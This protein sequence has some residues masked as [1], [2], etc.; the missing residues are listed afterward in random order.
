MITGAVALLVVHCGEDETTGPKEDPGSG[1]WSNCFGNHQLPPE[2]LVKPGRLRIVGQ[3]RGGEAGVEGSSVGGSEGGASGGSG[4]GEAGAGGLV[5]PEGAGA[6]A[7][8]AGSVQVNGELHGCGTALTITQTTVLTGANFAADFANGVD[9]RGAGCARAGAASPDAVFSVHVPSGATVI[10][11]ETAR[12]FSIDPVIGFA[13]SCS[14][15]IEC[16]ASSAAYDVNAW[17]GVNYTAERDE[18]ITA[19]VSSER[20]YAAPYR[21]SLEYPEALGVVTAGAS[22]PVPGSEALGSDDWRTFR[23]DAA[24]PVVLYGELKSEG[25]VGDLDFRAFNSEAYFSTS[26]NDGDEHVAFGVPAGRFFVE[27]RAYDAVNGYSLNLFTDPFR[28]VMDPFD[29]TD[30]PEHEHD[31][32]AAIPAGRSLFYRITALEDAAIRINV[33]ANGGDPALSLYEASGQ[34]FRTWQESEGAEEFL[35]ARISAVPSSPA[36]VLLRVHAMPEGGE[37]SSHRVQISVAVE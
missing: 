36:V 23:I 14:N 37:I 26:F 5:Q 11:R 34:F 18:T 30:N 33:E 21:I 27:A 7:G 10:L 9:F 4:E 28:V 2:D 17:L 22:L 13:R 15:T 20:N 31:E 12:D 16:E 1:T 24:E 29:L 19:F 32:S 35:V 8:A 3:A 6:D 25:D